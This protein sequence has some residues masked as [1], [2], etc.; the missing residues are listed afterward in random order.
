[1]SADKN[2]RAIRDTQQDMADEAARM[3][4]GLEELDEHAD[5]AAKKAQVT[6]EQA[7]LEADE[8][9]GDGE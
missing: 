4:R 3:Q 6:R 2:E 9:P 7:D 8:P 1:M 5:E